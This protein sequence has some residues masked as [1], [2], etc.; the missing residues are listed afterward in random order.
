VVVA[1][2]FF[3]ALLPGSGTTLPLDAVAYLTY[4]PTPTYASASFVDKV[5]TPI[6]NSKL[7]LIIRVRG[8]GIKVERCK[9]RELNST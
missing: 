8:K 1:L 5:I 9:Q 7:W 4:S 2:I 3:P 6:S